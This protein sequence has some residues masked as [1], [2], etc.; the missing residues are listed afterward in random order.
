MR[1]PWIYRKRTNLIQSDGTLNDG[2][3][4]DRIRHRGRR[5][6]PDSNFENSIKRNR[7]FLPQ[8][9]TLLC[10]GPCND[11]L[12]SKSLKIVMEYPLKRIHWCRFSGSGD[13]Q[14]QLSDLTAQ[15][16]TLSL[17]LTF[18]GQLH[19]SKPFRPFRQSL[20][21]VQKRASE[22]ATLRLRG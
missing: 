19:D 8:A 16:L 14:Y 15:G 11:Y 22:Y 9:R 13:N 5:K 21:T 20:Q 3:I 4:L 1:R 6:K 18:M 2:A 17:A 7:S 10:A 12:P